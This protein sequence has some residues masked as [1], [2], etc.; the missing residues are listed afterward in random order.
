MYFCVAVSQESFSNSLIG[1]E[2]FS[3]RT[4]RPIDGILTDTTS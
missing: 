3:F 4:I 1:Y 2:K